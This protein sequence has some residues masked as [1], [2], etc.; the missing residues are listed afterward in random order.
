VHFNFD[1][2][3]SNGRISNYYPDFL[4]KLDRNRVVIVETKGLED[5]DVPLKMARLAK[6]CSDINAA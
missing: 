3:T 5:I 1:Y 6:W 4:V 2:V